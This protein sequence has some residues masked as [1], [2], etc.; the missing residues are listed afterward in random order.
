MSV[1]TLLHNLKHL[2]YEKVSIDFRL[3]S[4]D[5]IM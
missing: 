1:V 2:Y 4:H 3:G 5:G